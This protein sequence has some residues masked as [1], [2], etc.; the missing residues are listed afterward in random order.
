MRIFVLNKTETNAFGKVKITACENFQV[1]EC[2]NE[3]DVNTMN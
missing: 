2:K 3:R 1:N